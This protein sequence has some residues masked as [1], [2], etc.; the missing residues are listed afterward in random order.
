MDFGF[1]PQNEA[2]RQEVRQFLEENV[3]PELRAELAARGEEGTAGPLLREFR[4]KLGE[5]GWAGMS[6]PKEYGGQEKDRIDQFVFEEEM[7]RAKVGFGLGGL[8]QAIA[9]MTAGSDEQ[10]QYFLPRLVTG[11]VSFALGYTEPSGGTD[12]ASLQTRAEADGD[13]F[14]INGQKM[15]TSGAHN[16]THLY[17]MARTDPTLPKHRGIS[18]FLVP[19]DTP[20]IT[21]TPL[22]TIVGTRTNMVYLDDVRVHRSALLGEL[23]RG[24]YIGSA[25][26]NLG[27]GG[28]GRYHE[29]VEAFE[30][31]L[32]YVRE[33]RLNG[34]RLA[35]EPAVRERLAE[36]YCEAQVARLLL[37]RQMS[38]EKR[39]IYN[40]PY[41]VSASKVWGPEFWVKSTQV[42][43]Q[44]L[45]PYG[46][47]AA[48][49][50]VAPQDGWFARKYLGAARATFAHGGV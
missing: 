5:K 9:I 40:P 21:V 11:E 7:V 33:T 20:G 39:G 34:H 38:L 42:I 1:T 28:A 4:R 36:L 26:L 46:Q 12:L 49:S 16:S 41:E 31:I 24:W 3:T 43:T 29:N 2:F 22:W 23:N 17:L 48:G 8:E 18:I 32:D 13:D 25:A 10:K 35:D 50:D 15:F 27:R 44:I 47:L 37:W 19:M 45:G 6:W 14:V 30:G